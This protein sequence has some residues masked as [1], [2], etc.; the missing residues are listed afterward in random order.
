ME[1]H[2]G[3]SIGWSPCFNSGCYPRWKVR[4]LWKFETNRWNLD[5][6]GNLMMMMMIMIYLLTTRKMNA[7]SGMVRGGAKREV[8]G[9]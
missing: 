5:D 2:Q 4:S 7:K 3:T 1:P 9:G 6:Y 8:E